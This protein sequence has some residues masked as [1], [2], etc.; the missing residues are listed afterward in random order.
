MISAALVFSVMLAAQPAPPAAPS[1]KAPPTEATPVLAAGSPAPPL[2]VD[3]WVK[4]DAVKA[5]VPGKVYVVEFWATWCPP[6]VKNIPNL[7]ALQKRHP[8]L[9]VIGVAASE[10]PKQKPADGGADDGRLATVQKFV[11]SRGD[12]MNYRVAFDGDAS[13]G[14]AWM[15]AAKQRSIPWACIV[16]GKGTIAWMGHP[17]LMDRE[18]ERVLKAN[19][20]APPKATP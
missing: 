3:A 18:I 13:M 4:G 15:L 12:G 7:N 6:C 9:T 14:R 2:T 5:F 19:K 17:E 20:P 11:E 1:D 16:D 10:R 8:E